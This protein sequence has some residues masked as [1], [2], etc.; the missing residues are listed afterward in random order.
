MFLRTSVKVFGLS[1]YMHK[2]N[3][4][5]YLSKLQIHQQKSWYKTPSIVKVRKILSETCTYKL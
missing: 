5:V 3:L 4:T 2:I 1:G